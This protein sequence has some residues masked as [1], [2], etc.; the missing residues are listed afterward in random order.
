MTGNEFDKAFRCEGDVNF[1]EQ[2]E[3]WNKKVSPTRAGETL[4]D[5]SRYFLH[6]AL[7]TPC[8][9]TL[10][11]AEGIYLYAQSGEK[12]MDFHGNNVH[13]LGYKNPYILE[14]IKKQMDILPFCPRRYTNQVAVDCAKELT[15]LLPEEMNRVLFMPGGTLAIGTALKLARYVTG[16]FRVISAWD[17]FHGASLD[18]ISVGGEAQFHQGMGPLLPGVEHIPPYESKGIFQGKDELFYADYLE[19]VLQKESDVGAFVIETIRNTDV[20]I[21]SKAYWK[22]IREICDK[23]GVMLILDEIPIAFGRT[24]KMFAFEHFDIEPDILC[25]GKG[26]GGG[27]FPMAA[28][29]AKDRYN[30][31]SQISLGHYTHEKSP[32]GC[33]AAMAVMN[34]IQEYDILA[35]VE[36]DAVYMR[37]LLMDLK[38]RHKCVGD[39][40][41]IGLLWAVDL[42]REDGSP[43]LE[44][45]ERVLYACLRRGLSFKISKGYTIQLSPPLII[46]REQLAEAIH[47][48]DEVL[49]SCQKDR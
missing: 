13:Q 9:D 43:D 18:A 10:D 46:E 4:L 28:I 22:R 19:Y 3:S 29:V 20:Q 38:T 16:K 7:S 1:S 42:T 33:A 21:P 35:K 6:Q 45:A 2:R 12:Y 26:M 8:L 17:S 49:D 25:L 14:R 32:L 41:G 24:G 39:I 31:A 15:S 40:R 11:N 27:I 36:R 47:I 30:I 37:S 48:L 34:Y 5:D 44:L 23:Y